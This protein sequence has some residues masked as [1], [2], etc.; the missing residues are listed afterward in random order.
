MSLCRNR[1]LS[2]KSILASRTT[3]SPFLVIASG[4]ISARLASF[5][6]NTLES[7]IMIFSAFGGLLAR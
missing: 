7:A 1:A 5:S 2:S 4:L 3:T 6:R